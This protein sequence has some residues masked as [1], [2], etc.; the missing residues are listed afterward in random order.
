MIREKLYIE[1]PSFGILPA[2]AITTT[3]SKG[4]ENSFAEFQSL[5]NI[6]CVCPVN[7]S[8]LNQK[9]YN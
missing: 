4:M 6:T 5:G 1:T 3:A 9:I 2:E 7:C 8:G